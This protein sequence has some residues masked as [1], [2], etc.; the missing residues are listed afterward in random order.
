ME[1]FEYNGFIITETDDGYFQTEGVEFLSV[2]DAMDWID[3]L[4]AD[5]EITKSAPQKLHTYLIFYVDNATDQA[6]ETKIKAR[7]WAEAQEI[8]YEE[9]DVYMVTD[10]TVLD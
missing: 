3:S 1:D 2:E 7:T 9:Y 10:F 5:A 8:L 6:F 4:L